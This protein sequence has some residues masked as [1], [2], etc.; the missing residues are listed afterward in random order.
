MV[1]F[2]SDKEECQVLT[3][4]KN[5]QDFRFEVE[6]PRDFLNAFQF[7]FEAEAVGKKSE[8]V[9]LLALDEAWS[10]KSLDRSNETACFC[11]QKIDKLSNNK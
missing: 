5:G 3:I 8:T 6:T 2:K 4:C 11:E 9:P 7:I 10:F 1:N